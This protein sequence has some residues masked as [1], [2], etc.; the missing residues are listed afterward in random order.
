MQ[1]IERARNQGGFAL[2]ELMVVIVIVG[3]LVAVAIPAFLNQR[4]KGQDACAK[5]Q[6]H[7]M[8]TALEIIFTGEQSYASV[9]INRLRASESS[10]VS[11]GACGTGTVAMV[12][13]LSGAACDTAAGPGETDYCISQS[14]SSGRT[15]LVA[16]A[17]GGQVVR[18][19]APAG[20]GCKDGR[21]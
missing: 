10:I 18:S 16:I 12:G 14:S 9:D 1:L 21:W 5:S 15:Y 6:L 3:I 17:P 7:T 8:Q 2:I 11:S 4:E 13:G 19:C 20:A